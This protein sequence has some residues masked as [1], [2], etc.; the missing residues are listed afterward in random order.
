LTCHSPNAISW[1]ASQQVCFL[2]SIRK[3]LW[4]RSKLG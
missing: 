1:W 4:F 2:A 3:V